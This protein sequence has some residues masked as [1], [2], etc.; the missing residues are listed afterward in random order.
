MKPLLIIE[1]GHAPG[2]IR[3]RLGDFAHWFRVA[4]RVSPTRIHRVDVEAGQALP[5]PRMCAGA[6]ITGSAAM[7]T[8]KHPWSEDTAAWIVDAMHAQ[9]PLFG[10]CYGHQLMAHALGGRVGELPG[11]REIGTQAIE[12]LP[13]AG[14]D[15][16]LRGMPAC[17]RTHTTHRQS[18]LELPAQARVLARSQQEPHQILRYGERAVSTQFHP[19]FSVAAMQAYVRLRASQLRAEGMDVHA[20][21]AQTRAT[22]AAR[23]LLQ[24]FATHSIA[25]ATRN[26]VS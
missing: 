13:A 2:P 16:L 9:L 17:F 11:G 3:A 22:P 5:P 6:V 7:V 20:L 8:D 23:R 26:G 24:R 12:L 10:V 18:V 21:L 15:M 19:E 1:T 25:Q 14:D 4:M